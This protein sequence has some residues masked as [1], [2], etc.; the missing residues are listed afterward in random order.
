MVGVMKSRGRLDFHYHGL[1]YGH[2][3]GYD[4][5]YGYENGNEN[6]KTDG[7]RNALFWD[8][9]DEEARR[10]TLLAKMREK[11]LREFSGGKGGSIR[12][13]ARSVFGKKREGS[14][15]RKSVGDEA[16]GR[17]VPPVPPLPG[18]YHPP[19]SSTPGREK[20][21]GVEMYVTPPS[22]PRSVKTVSTVSTA[23]FKKFGWHAGSNSNMRM[24]PSVSVSPKSVSPKSTNGSGSGSSGWR[25]TLRRKS[26]APDGFSFARTAKE[27]GEEDVGVRRPSH[28]GRWWKR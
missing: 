11:E 13:M 24:G 3:Q 10:E 4:H 1:E 25:D 22:S 5:G 2:D 12:S 19:K 21:S 28:D 8:A 7:D 26:S 20:E 18:H 17:D 6:G 23:I 27:Q 16:E 15:G 9:V 14:V